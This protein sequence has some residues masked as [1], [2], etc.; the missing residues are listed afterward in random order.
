MSATL[1]A[2]RDARP[3]TPRFGRYT[4]SGWWRRC[5]W[6]GREIQRGEPIAYYSDEGESAHVACH[7]EACS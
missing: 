1:E 4:R 6:C 2:D 3:W 7:L 5:Y